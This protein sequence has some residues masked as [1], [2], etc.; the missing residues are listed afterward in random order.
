VLME[1]FRRWSC[2]YYSDWIFLILTRNR[3]HNLI[4]FFK[5]VFNYL[6]RPAG[7]VPSFFTNM[8]LLINIYFTIQEIVVWLVKH[9]RFQIISIL[10]LTSLNMDLVDSIW[11]EGSKWLCITIR[12]KSYRSRGT[13]HLPTTWVKSTEAGLPRACHVGMIPA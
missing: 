8:S 10:F 7:W 5:H 12:N 11:H 6:S 2:N 9:T 4:V 1:N 3:K 13:L